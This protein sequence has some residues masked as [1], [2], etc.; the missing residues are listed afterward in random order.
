MRRITLYGLYDI[1]DQVVA[2]LELHIDI[3]PRRVGLLPQFYQPVI[4]SDAPYK[5][6]GNSE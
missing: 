1:G 3:S 4:E 5:N 2:P 6:C